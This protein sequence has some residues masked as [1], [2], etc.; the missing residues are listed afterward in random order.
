GVQ[1]ESSEIYDQYHRFERDPKRS[2]NQTQFEWYIK[3][4]KQIQKET[5]R[6]LDLVDYQQK[7]LFWYSFENQTAWKLAEATCKFLSK[8]AELIGTRI[9]AFHEGLIDL[10]RVSS[11]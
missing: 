9:L 3:M 10:N 8:E 7:V 1:K 4:A 6:R 2:L 11:H 5:E